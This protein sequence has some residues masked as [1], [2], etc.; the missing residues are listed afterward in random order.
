M[1]RNSSKGWMEKKRHQNFGPVNASR[2][3]MPASSGQQNLES[4]WILGL[5]LASNQRQN[6]V[7][8][9][10]VFSKGVLAK[11]KD[12]HFLQG[13]ARSNYKLVSCFGC[14]QGSW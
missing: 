6:L 4:R 14:L 5:W 8:T 1:E 10:K 9:L 12:N 7:H 2:V 13:F 11:L 3:K